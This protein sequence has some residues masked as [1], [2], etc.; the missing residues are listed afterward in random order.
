[1]P[2]REKLQH[3]SA[4]S[5]SLQWKEA[6]TG[7]KFLS[8]LAATIGYLIILMIVLNRFLPFINHRDGIALYDPLLAII[9]SVDLSVWIFVIIYGTSATMFIYLL[10]DPVRF[11]QTLISLAFVYTLRIATLSIVPLNPPVGCIPLADPIATHFAYGG[12]VVTKDLFF[13]GH[14]AFACIVM[15]AAKSRWLKTV[16]MAALVAI[17]IM[18]LFQHAHYTIDILG[19]LILAPLCWKTAG[20]IYS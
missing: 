17:M 10:P 2:L 14:T 6:L 12:I 19:A 3:Y 7:K 20:K 15:L 16:M 9:P 8:L 18:L 11:L 1:M 5:V 13:S 4:I